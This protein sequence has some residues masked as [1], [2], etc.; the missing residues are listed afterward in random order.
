MQNKNNN[1]LS[2]KMKFLF[3]VDYIVLARTIFRFF[4]FSVLCEI[5]IVIDQQCEGSMLFQAL[6]YCKSCSCLR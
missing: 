3:I 1:S 4:T 5:D 6:R 2:I